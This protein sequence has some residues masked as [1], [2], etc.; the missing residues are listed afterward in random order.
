MRSSLDHLVWQLVL[1]NGA[2]PTK[3]NTFPICNTPDCFSSEVR[4]NRLQGV[5]PEAQAIIDGWQPYRRGKDLC[6]LHPLW[7]LSEFTNIDKH[8]TLNLTT[9][10]ANTMNLQAGDFTVTVVGGEMADG[11]EVMRDRP[12]RLP[13]DTDMKAEDSMYVAFQEA[14]ARNRDVIIALQEIL[15][16]I[17]QTVVHGFEPFFS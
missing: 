3:R 17:R 1:A 11:A 12:E 6:D 15:D 7:I 10:I 14:P 13:R 4:K 8:R 9:V 5:S 2:T 16:F